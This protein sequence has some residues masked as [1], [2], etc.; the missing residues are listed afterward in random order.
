MVEFV[1]IFLFIFYYNYY[2]ISLVGRG[3][4]DGCILKRN[5]GYIEIVCE[6]CKCD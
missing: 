3:S 1:V 6:V 4:Y 2:Y 5:G